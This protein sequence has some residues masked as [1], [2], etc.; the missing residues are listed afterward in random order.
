MRKHLVPALVLGSV[1]GCGGGGDL[2][3]AE[4]AIVAPTCG[5]AVVADILAPADATHT[6]IQ[7]RCSVT[8][9][10]STTPRT[11][12]KRI[13]I[14]GAAASG[15]H[16]DC[17]GARLVPSSFD[18]N[19][20][21]LLI[22]SAKTGP[23][24]FAPPTDVSIERCTIQGA[25][26][27][28]GMG[29][30]GQAPDVRASSR[31]DANHTARA[32]AAAPTRIRLSQV[33]II[34]TGRIP[35]Y[36]AP[37]VNN[38]RVE[39]SSI[40][41][42]SNATAIYLDAESGHNVFKNNSI[43]T[44]STSRELVA[45]DGSAFNLFV[46]NQFTHLEDGGI[47]LYRNC[48]EGGTVR[49]QSPV[50]NQF[51]N[52]RFFYQNSHATALDVASR[53]G[54]ILWHNPFD[55][56]SDDDGFPW[57]SS[58]NDDDLVHNTVV[59]QNQVRVRAPSEV[60]SFNDGPNHIALNTSVAELSVIRSGCF[61]P[62]LGVFLND[63]ESLPLVSSNGTLACPATRVSCADGEL[64]RSLISGACPTT[65]TVDFGCQVSGSDA[66]C[67]RSFS[68]PA[69]TRLTAV[70]AACDLETGSLA[71]AQLNTT[72]WHNLRVARA[73]DRV[74]DGGCFVGAASAASG[75]VAADVFRATGA[76]YGCHEHDSN[77]GD[78]QILG[79][80][81]CVAP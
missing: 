56:C 4:E 80:A 76:S 50:W 30:N 35:L 77:G 60:F 9:P 40:Q 49:H 18:S 33:T 66:G 79:Q 29:S 72:A 2:E 46:G 71:V 26:R 17:S 20:E 70:R 73:S 52:N 21:R 3:S 8:L 81:L 19:P 6:A 32:Q 13:L 41:G 39:S 25:V 36:L 48:G 74:S 22:A 16:L 42:S 78:C 31:Q 10:P 14:T 59:I 23:T 54:N 12:T 15:V 7:L 75:A 67:S 5:P 24:S 43:S 62:E 27:I 28:L 34:G 68:C 11:I 69:G 61:L 57:G 53:T 45:I 64:S 37:G 55:F 44:D 65:V 58:V 38:V 1:C 51:I 63:G 47:F